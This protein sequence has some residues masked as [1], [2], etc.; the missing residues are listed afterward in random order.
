M[1]A[2]Q[3]PDDSTLMTPD[4]V[5]GVA[6]SSYQIEGAVN[7]G[8]RGIS[9]W[10]T[11]CRVPGAVDNNENGDIACDHY[12]L[13]RQDIDMIH[14]LG[15]DAYRFSISWP[16]IMPI[17]GIINQE[18]LDFYQKII[19]ECHRKGM[20]VYVTLYH[21]DLPQ[22]LE[23]RGGWLNRETAYKFAEY[24]DVVSRYFANEIDVY[25]TLNEPLVSAF[26]GY[27]WGL[28][29]PGVI[30][31]REGFQAAHHLML[32]H[33]LAMPKL[34]ENSPGSQHGLVVNANT[35]YAETKQDEAAIAMKEADGYLWFIE[36]VLNG[37]YPEIVFKQ[38]PQDMPLI[39]D[40]DLE[41]I[42]APIDY[43][44]I[45]Y[46][47]RSVVRINEQGI[48]ESVLQPDSEHTYIG[49]EIYPQGLTDLLVSLHNRYEN[50]PPLYITENGA[51]CNDEL[52][53]GVVN[54]VQRVR[55]YQK[56][57]EAVDAAVR[58]GVSVKGYF[59]WS[60]MDNFEWAYGY[61]QRFG[62]VYVDY[63]TQQRTLKNSALAYREML[64]R[65]AEE[66]E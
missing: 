43:L 2:Y 27:R 28:H 54:D 24:A 15:V 44:G 51:A 46:Y 35:I 63:K 62:M 39:L 59:A 41:I 49:W 36:P 34:R 37:Q 1:K 3:L 16:R 64:R 4:F 66:T 19:D 11:F 42:S 40:G 12:N 56:H 30:G 22:Y 65:R 58:A 25:T 20:K 13:W 18:G 60:L 52:I 17:E 61:R 7:E 38:K 23:D 33:G 5:F 50:L 32:G 31:E 10:D 8:C 55:Y 29:A 57:L 26:L 48:S 14:D 6:T 9:I 45:N 21:W 53:D 47:T